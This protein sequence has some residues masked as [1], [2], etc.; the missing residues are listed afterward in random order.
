[1]HRHPARRLAGRRACAGPGRPADCRSSA[2][3]TLRQRGLVVE[4][5]PA[6]ASPRRRR[7]R[8]GRCP[9]PAGR[10]ASPRRTAMVPLPDAAGPVDGDHETHA[11]GLAPRSR[12][13][14]AHQRREAGEAG[15]DHAG[16]VDATGCSRG[17]AQHQ[18]AHG[19]AVIAV[20]VPAGAAAHRVIG[21]AP[22]RPR[23][24]PPAPP[25]P[26]RRRRSGRAAISASRSLSLTRSSPR[27]RMTVAPLGEGGGDGQDRI[28]VD[29][30]GAPAPAG[31]RRRASGVA[32]GDVADRLAALLAH[33]LRW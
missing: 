13:Q 15:G 12:A 17:E 26:R 6:R 2:A 23:S 11:S 22:R 24:G 20:G 18:V 19:D 9:A 29:H 7:D 28:F 31:P 30:R 14:A 25:R 33:V 21:A 3:A 10:S 1:M 32:R 5:P 8:A 16:F 4:V 27:P